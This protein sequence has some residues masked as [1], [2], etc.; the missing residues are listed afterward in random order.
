MSRVAIVTGAG[1]GVGKATAVKLSD[2]G[3]TVILIGRREDKLEET[4]K[5]CNAHAVVLPLDVSKETDVKKCFEMV[6][7]TFSRLDLLFNNAGTFLSSKTIDK[8]NFNEWKEVIEV[9]LN[10]IFLFS[11]YAF[12]LMKNQSPKGGRIINNGSVSSITP[13][14][15]SIAYTAT[16]HAVTGM[17]KSLALDGRPFGIVCSQINIG[18]ADTPMTKGIQNGIVQADG[19]IRKETTFDTEHVADAVLHIAS[20]PLNTNILN[21]TIMASNM[22]FIGRG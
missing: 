7:N 15:G 21:M 20:L 1:T 2:A 6:Q 3:F 18:N 4:K 16:K 14:P 12:A 22:P 17:T 9:N 8:I 10:G 13:R 5:A 11:K 19:S